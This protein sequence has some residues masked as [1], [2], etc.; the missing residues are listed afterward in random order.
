[1]LAALHPS[2]TASNYQRRAVFTRLAKCVYDFVLACCQ[3]GTLLARMKARVTF[4][5][6]I[7]RN[8]RHGTGRAPR[9]IRRTAFSAGSSVDLHWPF[10]QGQFGGV[11]LAEFLTGSKKILQS[12]A[13]TQHMLHRWKLWRTDYWLTD[14]CLLPVL[15][16]NQHGPIHV[17]ARSRHPDRH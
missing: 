2:I 8:M 10:R 3:F 7:A 6:L 4:T 14:H 13:R 12:A 11:L 17:F 5:T 1:M 16:L 15:V 9:G